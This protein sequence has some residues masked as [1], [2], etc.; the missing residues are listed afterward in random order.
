VT[1]HLL[2][3]S[4]ACLPVLSSLADSASAAKREAIEAAKIAAEVAVAAVKSGMDT[5]AVPAMLWRPPAA[6]RMPDRPAAAA[7]AAV[8][9]GAAGARSS[10]QAS[11][12]ASPRGGSSPSGSADDGSGGGSGAK[13]IAVRDAAAF[14]SLAADELMALAARLVSDRVPLQC[15]VL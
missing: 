5:V 15:C 9:A 10:P 13:L 11:P 7:A 6:D 3:S 2:P 14:L 4:L 1:S 8:A 12:K